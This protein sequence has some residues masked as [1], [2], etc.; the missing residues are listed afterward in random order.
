MNLIKQ[1]HIATEDT[2]FSEGKQKSVMLLVFKTKD[3]IRMIK[4]RAG[5]VVKK[6]TET[7]KRKIKTS[8][9]SVISVSSVAKGF[10]LSLLLINSPAVLAA[11]PGV[12]PGEFSVDASGSA[13]Y[14]VPIAVPPGTAGMQPSL[15][16]SYNS[17]SGNGVLGVG[18]TLG[19]LS[20]ITR[21]PANKVIDG[22]IDG[23]DF[24]AN[25]RFCID[26]QR[27]IAVSGTYGAD[28]TEY[29][30][31][32]DGFT[33]VVSYDIDGTNNGPEY[34]IA[35]TK[36]GQILEYGN[37]DGVTNYH[38][39]IE[40]QGK[41]DV[42]LWA[43]NKIEDTVG[44]YL[45]VTYIEDNTNGEYRP[46]QIDYTGNA[47]ATPAL[48]PNTSVQ[49]EYATRTDTT[50]LY[51]AGSKVKNTQRLSNIKTYTDTSLVRDYQLSYDNNGEAN[52]SRLTELQECDGQVTQTCFSQSRLSGSKKT[53]GMLVIR[54]ISC[55]H[56][57]SI[58]RP[59]I[60]PP[61]VSSKM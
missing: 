9:I 16:L 26:G 23:I 38:S 13:N 58:I 37:D 44:N 14:Q 55:R 10:C 56:Q 45:T 5:I 48:T 54:A 47:N 20:V 17:R 33:K 6:K 3:M 59:R 61:M 25:D 43:V 7:S 36:S 29:R 21:C 8:V 28:Q 46:I 40:A 39:R 41:T 34:F 49:F 42:R 11:T 60:I 35:K 32:V 30:T 27:L 24:D 1:I 4:Y 57:L 2:E 15:T 12:T 31:E 18:W 50:T 19:G 53:Q 22:V 52:R 51:F